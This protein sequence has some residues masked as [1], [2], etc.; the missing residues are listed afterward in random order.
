MLY[1]H[2]QKILV[3]MSLA[4]TARYCIRVTSTVSV[5]TLVMTADGNLHCLM[6]AG[7]I[8]RFRGAPLRFLYGHAKGVLSVVSF[9]G[10]KFWI[11]T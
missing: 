11:C 5:P 7:D 6:F 3:A 4:T 2:Y 10:S 8:W 1:S 9:A